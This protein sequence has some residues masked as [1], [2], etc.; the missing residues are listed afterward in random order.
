MTNTHKQLTQFHQGSQK[1]PQGDLEGDLDVFVLEAEYREGLF[2]EVVLLFCFGVDVSLVSVA[3]VR[4]AGGSEGQQGA[5]QEHE[6]HQQEKPALR[7]AATEAAR[8]TKDS[9]GGH[10][11]GLVVEVLK[12][13]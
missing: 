9:P 10:L 4:G 3:H 12:R 13:V 7:Q 5:L 1:D 11:S 6:E 2:G 8:V